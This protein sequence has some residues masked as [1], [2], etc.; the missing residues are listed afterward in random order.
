MEASIKHLREGFVRED[1]G[2]PFLVVRDSLDVMGGRDFA[3]QVRACMHEMDR[4]VW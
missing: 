2:C 3:V 1:A 4:H